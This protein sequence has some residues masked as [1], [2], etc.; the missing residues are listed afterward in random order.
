MLGNYFRE[1][2]EKHN[3]VII[4][5][6]GAFLVKD[7]GDVR[8][9]KNTTFSPFLR[10]NDGLVENFLAEREEL[11]KVDASTKVREYVENLKAQIEKGEK[12][13]LPGLGYFSL[14]SRGT[15]QFTLDT[16]KKSSKDTDKPA[17]IKSIENLKESEKAIPAAE[18]V[19]IEKEPPRAA[20][21][22]STK[23]PIAKRQPSKVE[24]EKAVAP[25]VT[26]KDPVELVQPIETKEEQTEV[27]ITTTENKSMPPK[28]S[29]KQK[30]ASN[31]SGRNWLLLVFSL[32]VVLAIAVWQYDN[33][34]NLFCPSSET[35][36]TLGNTK[37]IA[38]DTTHKDT[39]AAQVANSNTPPAKVK[40]LPVYVKPV[41]DS[42]SNKFFVI[43]GTFT[44]K[45]NAEAMKT[46]LEAEGYQPIIMQR[47]NGLNSVVI[48]GHKTK[49]E[50]KLSLESYKKKNGDG[51]IMAR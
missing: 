49:A 20:K 31:K 38:V 7:T 21:K 41:I 11:T 37:T 34:A 3:R 23:P 12:V 33:I 19:S 48:S 45:A 4:P 35:T 26:S 14:D 39:T 24:E 8:D 15:T 18:P 28:K 44:S 46:K 25:E 47:G 16:S 10:Y 27:P 9:I 5:D 6:F 30:S 1:L 29:S 51:W 17:E 36:F 13:Y 2:L 50:A 42:P 22:T 43:V 40:P 32:I